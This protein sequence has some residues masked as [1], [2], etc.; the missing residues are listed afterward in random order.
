VSAAIADTSAYTPLTLLQD[1]LARSASAAGDKVALVCGAER[2]TYRMLDE[3]SSALAAALVSRGVQRGDR[4][5]LYADNTPEAVVSLWAVLK[6]DA[7]V[8]PV[9]PL[10]KA[11][12]LLRVIEDCQASALITDAHLYRQ[13]GA[14][15]ASA[16]LE[17]V[18]YSGRLGG[19]QREALPAG[20]AWEQALTE[21]RAASTASRNG[22]TALA[23]LLYTAG[24]DGEPLGIMLTHANMLA[25]TAS[26]GSC[27]ALVRDDVVVCALPL[28]SEHGLYPML[29]AGLAGACVVLERSFAFPGEVLGRMAAERVTVF[30]A[31]PTVIRILGS[32]KDPRRYD[33]CAVRAVASAGAGLS[34]DELRLLGTWFPQARIHSTYGLP[35]CGRCACLPPADVAEKYGRIGLA[36]PG[37]TL[38][39]VDEAGR[40]AP[41]GVPGELVVSGAAVMSGY[42]N[43]PAETA[44]KLESGARRLHTGALFTRDDEGYLHFVRRLDGMLECRGERVA[45][46]E[47]EAVV[48]AIDG[49]REAAA[50]GMPD[51]M[52]GE[53]VK[54]FV[55]PEPGATL[56][57]HD[58]LRACIDKLENHRVPKFVEITSAL[59]R[60]SSV[61]DHVRAAA[62][63]HRFEIMSVRQPDIIGSRS[64]P[65][66]SRT[67]SV[68]G[69]P[70]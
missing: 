25:A 40:V 19:A 44:R 67:S 24:A 58:V 12:K 17:C 59:P 37:M 49:V 1:A 35:E 27:L 41:A 54:V 60:T 8:C 38:Q 39:V 28:T 53:A 34:A 32:L 46:A 30:P 43:R 64:C 26:L 29:A 51:A 69:K 66:G 68:R 23:A 13:W 31:V 14:A 63:H 2:L 61:R 10:T 70:Q 18:V 62:G 48:L 11:G 50:V 56:S 42:W 55:V 16:Q 9:N 15:C 21:G 20:V 65:C 6:A 57:A 36:L 7:V 4:V 5:V 45:P 22:D 33:L 3:R 47:I 52:L